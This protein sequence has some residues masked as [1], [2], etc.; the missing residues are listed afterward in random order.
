M[1]EYVFIWLFILEKAH[2]VCKIHSDKSGFKNLGQQTIAYTAIY[3]IYYIIL[4]TLY[5][6]YC[7]YF[8]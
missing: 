8:K 4:Y 1:Q 6:L 2:H 7:L 5:C 3:Y